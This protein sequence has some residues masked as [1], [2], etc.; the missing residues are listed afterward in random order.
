MVAYVVVA[1]TAASFDAREAPDPS[2]PRSATFGGRSR[3]DAAEVVASARALLTEPML[4]KAAGQGYRA[5]MPDPGRG[6]S[7]ILCNWCGLMV[8]GWVLGAGEDHV[9]G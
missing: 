3:T 8:P 7:R 1:L 6:L 4:D 5:L 2:R 9:C